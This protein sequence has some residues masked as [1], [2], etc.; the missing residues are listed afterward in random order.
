MMKLKKHVLGDILICFFILS[1]ITSPIFAHFQLGDSTLPIDEEGYIEYDFEDNLAPGPLR[2]KVD[3]V[4]LYKIYEPIEALGV[5]ITISEL[6]T[7]SN[8]YQVLI[9]DSIKC[10]N[11]TCLGYNKTLQYF[12]YN[13]SMNNLLLYGYGGYYIIPNDPVDVNIVKGFIEGYTNWSVNVDNNI[14]TIDT[15]NNQIILTYSE[16]GI[17]IKE[18]VKNN[19]IIISVL[20]FISISGNQTKDIGDMD[21]V[22]FVSIII[23]IGVASVIIK[24]IYIKNR[25]Y[26]Q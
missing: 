9:V 19:N 11:L 10:Q 23:L 15:T 22:L 24:K 17:L 6:N 4:D 25:E 16:E 26:I 21:V 20:T 8:K 14:I 13:Q 18:E 2:L 1:S 3:F 12:R 5:N 7:T